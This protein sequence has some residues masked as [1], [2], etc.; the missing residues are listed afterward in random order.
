MPEDDSRNQIS[1]E[2]QHLKNIYFGLNVGAMTL[3]IEISVFMQ[4]SSAGTS[5]VEMT[6]T[7][8]KLQLIQFI[9][10]NPAGIAA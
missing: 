3:S 8:R 9:K 6:H 2:L 7:T 5:L 10:L 4:S 1:L